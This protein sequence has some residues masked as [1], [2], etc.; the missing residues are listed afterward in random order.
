MT[1]AFFISGHGFGHASRQIE[2]INALHRRRPDLS[3]FIRSSVSRRLFDRSLTPPFE[4]DARP[5]DVGVVQIDALALDARATIARAREFYGPAFERQVE[6]EA[7][8]LRARGVDLVISDAPPL[9]CAAA[10][11][12]GVP[13]IV[14][15]NFTWDWIYE[16][17]REYLAG[18][19]DLVPTIRQA[20]G[21]AREAW[22]LPMSGGFEAVR[23]TRDV[24]L[25]ARHARHPRDVTR[26]T[27]DLPLEGR[28]VLSSFGGYD[29]DGIDLR[30]LD[31]RPG[32]T[33]VVT[34]LDARPAMPPRVMVIPETRL[35]DAGLRYEDLVAACDVVVSKPG[36]GIVSECIAN[37]PALV[38]T[39][40]GR[41][42]EYAVL[43]ADLPKYVRCAYLTQ[44]SLRAG[45]WRAALDAAVAAPDPPERPATNGADIIADM[46]SALCSLDET[47]SGPLP[48]P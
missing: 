12:A 27:L 41:F 26:R 3:V 23:A 18:A 48:R 7:R 30:T 38:Y 39:D 25:V 19:P 40:R 34:S 5:C 22:R 13:S 8:T 24:P 6:A 35:Y 43:V 44:T 42:A 33:V 46:M 36:Y 2:I 14:I 4:L 45:R 15:A 21:C 20:Y 29:V 9:A 16:E 28:L 17:Y 32:W 1:C 11:R 10:S 37:G 31:I 47:S